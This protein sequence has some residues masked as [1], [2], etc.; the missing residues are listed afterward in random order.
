MERIEAAAYA[1]PVQKTGLLRVL[2][3]GFGIAVTI[4]GIFGIGILRTPATVAAHL[5]S[6]RLIIGIWVLGALYALFGTLASAE[7]GTSLPKAGGWY[8]YARRAFGD[9]TGFTIG[10]VNW[11]SYCSATA[12]LAIALAEAVAA[13]APGVSHWTKLIAIGVIGLFTVV[14][15][16]GIKTGSRAQGVTSLITSLA[17]CGLIAVCFIFGAGH[18]AAVE[19]APAL[20]TPATLG[21]LFFAIVIS[22]QS[23]IFTYDG[24]YGA[25]YFAEE[26]SNPGR[27]LPKAMLSATAIVIVVYMLMNLALLYVLPVPRLAG[28]E[29]AAAEAARV[30]L[31][32]KG[33]QIITIVTL[34]STLSVLNATILQTPRILFAM[35]RDG[36]LAAKASQVNRGGTPTIALL[37]TAIV[38]I[39]LVASGTFDKLVAITALFFVVMYC[40]GFIALIVLRF[41][42]PNLTR[43]FKAWG[44]P[45]TV[46]FVIA[47]SVVFLVGVVISDTTNSLYGLA[48]LAASYPVYLATRKLGPAKI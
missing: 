3:V 25:I 33:G 42:E 12:S 24:W 17:F 18:R 7:L 45:W 19:N 34:I 6:L 38:A 47:V 16:I 1:E 5:G 8:V 46:I 39:G 4:G 29:L 21:A 2:G 26:D 30:V 36:L 43:P 40:S 11:L 22:L 20:T 10:W 23:V 35:S 13:L 15:W 44:Y 32:S 37:F 31:G 28:S 48:L 41:R 27:N 14:H 9:Y